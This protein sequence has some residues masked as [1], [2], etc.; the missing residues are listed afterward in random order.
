[1]DDIFVARVMSSTLHTANRDTLV[2]D[3]AN[4]MLDGDVGSILVLDEE[5]GIEGI[6]TSSDFVGIVAASKPKAQTTVGRYMSEDVVTTTA[7]TSIREAADLMVEHGIH[8]LPVVDGEEVIGMLSTSDMTAYLSQ[9][10][11]PTPA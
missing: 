5:G 4:T 7:Q 10:E 6:L 1:M 3:A 2:E 9:E 8:Y 11:D